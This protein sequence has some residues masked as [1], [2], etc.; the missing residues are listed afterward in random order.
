[1]RMPKPETAKAGR[2]GLGASRIGAC[3][4]QGLHSFTRLSRPRPWNAKASG[5]SP[6]SKNEQQRSKTIKNR[7]LQGASRSPELPHLHSPAQPRAATTHRRTQTTTPSP[8]TQRQKSCA[9][10]ASKH[11]LQLLAGSF[12]EPMRTLNMK[13]CSWASSPRRAGP[14]AV[15]LATRRRLVCFPRPRCSGFSGGWGSGGGG[16]G[17][18]GGICLDASPCLHCTPKPPSDSQIHHPTR[19][20]DRDL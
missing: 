20:W 11:D 8:P 4:A 12:R 3:D 18:R 13:H 16:E 14:P 1:M 17:G 10:D 6:Y 19:R 7:K 5:L 15:P 9:H 2:G